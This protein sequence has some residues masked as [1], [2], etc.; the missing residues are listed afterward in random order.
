MIGF[1]AGDI[2]MYMSGRSGQR[3]NVIQPFRYEIYQR[4]INLYFTVILLL[5]D[6]IIQCLCCT[7]VSY[8]H[9]D[10]YKRQVDKC[11]FTKNADGDLYIQIWMYANQSQRRLHTKNKRSILGHINGDIIWTVNLKIN[12]TLNQVTESKKE[13]LNCI[14]P[15]TPS[16]Y[17]RF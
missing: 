10:V 2:F 7:A 6:T 13:N 8:T 17:S 3:N 5:N 1:N 4:N 9:L 14:L 16:Y 15:L 11:R 12:L